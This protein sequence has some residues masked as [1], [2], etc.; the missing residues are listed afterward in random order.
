M[1]DCDEQSNETSQKRK[2]HVC[3]VSGC[4][5]AVVHLPRHLRTAHKWSSGKSVA[6]LSIFNLRFK[7][8]KKTESTKPARIH[9]RRV[10]PF[11]GCSAVVRRLHNHLQGKHKLKRTDEGYE[12][13]FTVCLSMNS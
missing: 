11:K 8:E 9:R 12:N 5:K 13:N 4:K 2:K 10:C 7:P 6:A 3:P 1:L